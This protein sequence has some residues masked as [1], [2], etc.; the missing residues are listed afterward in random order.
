MASLK[1]ATQL[2]PG[3][4]RY[5]Y[6]YAVALNSTGRAGD[7]IQVLERAAQRWPHDRDML[8]ALASFQLDAGKTQAARKTVD[9]L[10]GAISGRP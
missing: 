1:R 3:V 8:M 4:A 9:A 7:A 10:A 6:V 2:D 5:T